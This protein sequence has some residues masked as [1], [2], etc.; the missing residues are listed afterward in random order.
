MNTPNGQGGNKSTNPFDEPFTPEELIY[1]RIEEPHEFKQRCED[2][3]R[4]IGRT[5]NPSPRPS[6]PITPPRDKLLALEKEV[7]VHLATIDRQ[8]GE[9]AV[10]EGRVES[11]MREY[12]DIDRKYKEV[13][14]DNRELID[15]LK[16]I[17]RG[18]GR[19]GER[20]KGVDKGVETDRGDMDGGM[21]VVGQGKEYRP[22][23]KP[24]STQTAPLSSPQDHTS[25][26][27]VSL[28]SDLSTLQR[29]YTA[30]E[31]TCALLKIENARLNDELDRY[32]IDGKRKDMSRG[33]QTSFSV[34]DGQEMDSTIKADR[35][36]FISPDETLSRG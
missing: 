25:P 16:K 21:D 23:R 20:E 4:S 32:D 30:L 29:K 17:S 2:A 19:K 28:Q 15:N 33:V 18:I 10:L 1:A 22:N 24:A 12:R 14:R 13:K 6:R 34:H 5:A 31:N 11:V 26:V 3:I 7:S 9:I 35:F 8:G 36:S 27:A